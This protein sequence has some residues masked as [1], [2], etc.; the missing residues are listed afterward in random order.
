MALCGVN[1]ADARINASLNQ[2]IKL[3]GTVQ[4][5]DSF[6]RHLFVPCLIV[7]ACARQESQRALVEE[8]LSSLRATK[9]WILRSADFTSVLQHLWHGAAKDGRVTTWDDY[10]RSRRAML[11]VTE[12]QTPV[13]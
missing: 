1:S 4:H 11:P 7:G 6:D 13:F 2:I 5:T 10:V 9:M 8:K 12:G 3:L